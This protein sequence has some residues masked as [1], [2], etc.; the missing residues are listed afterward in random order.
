MKPNRF[1]FATSILLAM[2]F[3]YSYSSSGESYAAERGC[4]WNYKLQHDFHQ[5]GEYGEQIRINAAVESR[6]NPNCVEVIWEA[7]QRRKEEQRKEYLRKD[8]QRKII[9][10]EKEEENERRKE[11]SPYSYAS[12]GSLFMEIGFQ[13]IED[14]GHIRF[15]YGPLYCTFGGREGE[16]NTLSTPDIDN[17]KAIEWIAGFIYRRVSHKPDNSLAIGFGL[18]GGLGAKHSGYERTKEEY[19]YTDMRHELGAEFILGYFALYITERNFYRIGGGAG[20]IF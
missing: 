15:S 19:K 6:S 12:D 20:L 18:F 9:E 13:I 11:S 3:T 4:R 16:S 10:K 1:L 7:E 8:E 5:F 14:M 2:A 17:E